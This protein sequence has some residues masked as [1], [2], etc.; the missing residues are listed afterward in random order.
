MQERRSLPALDNRSKLK[1]PDLPDIGNKNYTD[2]ILRY[3]NLATKFPQLET[4]AKTIVAAI[5]EIYN[6]GSDV[7]PNPP[8]TPTAT[9]TK[10]GIDDV[11]Y[12]LD[13]KT[14]TAGK[15]LNISNANVIGFNMTESTPEDIEQ[16]SRDNP[17]VLFFTEGSPQGGGSIITS[18]ATLSVNNWSSMQQSV[19]VAGLKSTNTV[20]I[21]P[22]SDLTGNYDNYTA[23]GIRAIGQSNGSITFKCSTL[24]S[25]AIRVN[26]GF[27]EASS[28]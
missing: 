26:I 10:I 15:L 18:T 8:G 5:N 1:N 24:P 21:S 16:E 14:Y 9:L 2:T 27:F 13:G 19:T 7:I 20:I 22:V 23:A 11:I 12:K 17:N 4:N 28:S 25:V 3:G 6:K